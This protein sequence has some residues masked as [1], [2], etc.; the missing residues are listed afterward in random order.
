[1]SKIQDERQVDDE[2][3]LLHLQ[4]RMKISHSRPSASVTRIT[5]EPSTNKPS[6]DVPP[7][8]SANNHPPPQDSQAGV[9]LGD[10]VERS[11]TTSNPITAP[12]KPST[13]SAPFPE[14][15]HR[16]ASKF[17]LGR[18][19][20]TIPVAPA[21][22]TNINS[23]HTTITTT[24]TSTQNILQRE[25]DK[26]AS[27]IN[28]ENRQALEAMSQEEI[29]QAQMELL[30]KL[31]PKTIHFL[32]HTR[33]QQQQQQQQQNPVKASAISNPLLSAPVINNKE[34]YPCLASPPP[35]PTAP[36]ATTP[37]QQQNQG[38][39]SKKSLASRVRYDIDG[40]IVGLAADTEPNTSTSCSMYGSKQ[41]VVR[42]D[43]LR[44]DEGILPSGYTVSEASL[45][46][47][48]TVPQQ[49]VLALRLIKAVVLRSHPAGHNI[50]RRNNNTCESG[51][52]EEIVMK[53]LNN[54][55]KREDV[56]H[57]ALHEE[58]LVTRLRVAFD[59]NNLNVVSS[60][61]EALA[62]LFTPYTTTTTINNNNNNNN[63][64]NKS[65]DCLPWG[66]GGWPGVPLRHL[67]R[68]HAAAP[69]VAAPIDTHLQHIN[70]E[71]GG[72][73]G[74]GGEEVDERQ[75]GK[76]D[77]L[78]GLLNMNLLSR[79]VYVYLTLQA[80]GSIDAIIELLLACAMAGREVCRSVINTAGMKEVLLQLLSSRG[81]KEEEKGGKRGERCLRMVRLLAQSSQ[82]NCIS[83]FFSDD[84]GSNLR[85][86]VLDAL[87]LL[88]NPQ[89]SNVSGQHME[90]MEA[91]RLWRVMAAYNCH[92]ITMD[93]AFGPLATL[94]TTTTATTTTTAIT[95]EE[96]TREI[97]LTAG[98]LCHA[99]VMM[100]AHCAE[101]ILTMAV[102]SLEQQ[103]IAVIGTVDAGLTDD[104]ATA[105]V[106]YESI[107]AVLGY[108]EVYCSKNKDAIPSVVA[109]LDKT[110]L[111][112]S[113]ADSIEKALNGRSD[114]VASSSRSR[115]ALACIVVSLCVLQVMSGKI[116]TPSSS[117]SS[118]SMQNLLDTII[119]TQGLPCCHALINDLDAT[120]LQPWDLVIINS[121]LPLIRLALH[122]AWLS[123]T[124]MTVATVC[125]TQGGGGEEEEER[126]DKQQ[127]G[128]VKLA[129]TM[130]ATA[131]LTLP[132][133][134]DQSGLHALSIL[135]HPTA[136]K[137]LNGVV[138]DVYSGST[139]LTTPFD[140]HKEQDVEN[141]DVDADTMSKTLM[142][143]WAATWLG[144][145]REEEKQHITTFKTI[146]SQSRPV[147]DASNEYCNLMLTRL[148]VPLTL[149]PQG[150]SLPLSPDW[151]VGEIPWVPATS[152][153]TR[154][155]AA[156]AAAGYA[157]YYTLAMMHHDHNVFSIKQSMDNA[158]VV[159]SAVQLVFDCRPGETT[160]SSGTIVGDGGSITSGLWTD[161][162][163]RWSLYKMLQFH[164]KYL[165]QQERK[166][167]WT[168]PEAQSLVSQ[169]ASASYGDALFG[170]CVALLLRR[171]V[172]AT[173]QLE[174]LVMLAESRALHLLPSLHSCC[175]ISGYNL[176]E[177][178][179]AA[180]DAAVFLDPP[181]AQNE[182]EEGESVAYYLKLVEDGTLALCLDRQSIAADII[183]H[184]LAL[185]MY[186]NDGTEVSAKRK[187]MV[188]AVLRRACQEE[189][190]EEDGG[191]GN[192]VVSALVRWDTNEMIAIDVVTEER[193]EYIKEACESQG[194]M[195]LWKEVVKWSREA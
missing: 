99:G 165:K 109:R 55:L 176:S 68:P 47:R 132:P 89:H 67:L 9:F 118:S 141:T 52:G 172:P 96:V 146:S 162:L 14:A 97:Y 103:L 90:R 188:C 39:F 124:A 101:S 127:L 148:P 112:N 110:C 71:E 185:K 153:S 160:S 84:D 18:Q 149:S 129:I 19:R 3:E 5:R 57:H 179:L 184:R 38:G 91:L 13:T 27:S 164:P 86:A 126:E 177:S 20:K 10:V 33:K 105:V 135:T 21:T 79:I 7:P 59:D 130:A 64:N 120:L 87:L 159:K 152:S 2:L 131:L 62:A 115:N 181:R 189:E 17:A 11:P 102:Q 100:S 50:N 123:I 56:W 95:H 114:S 49:R 168:L 69:W 142:T 133:G 166:D 24:T 36:T 111:L 122:A 23:N 81:K 46:A 8:S 193:L 169:Y 180:A 74:G 37:K 140:T 154:A 4:E 190:E 138:K 25:E 167:E 155:A 48:S 104:D 53:R 119:T 22:T 72:G 88:T 144:M 187:A 44:T 41:S 137:Y 158:A 186:N 54:K 77:P 107:A 45:L 58:S 157:L 121:H 43:V 40:H 134:D 106:V 6:D 150:S 70:E 117:S 1:M 32:K 151:P 29:A 73:G 145:V 75:V 66:L 85:R 94:F 42:R 61:A 174:V 192:R 30:S 171:H 175:T 170:A 12:T 161:E 147:V 143:G 35:T 178:K 195:E 116:A 92:L 98:A 28:E 128:R 183:I 125:H 31:D 63:N 163:V 80:P 139:S 60:A 34:T 16:R 26:L 65:I 82:R 113:F 93:D 156:A 15:V 194:E 136:I 108:I 78:G 191:G 76:V 83:L 173:V 51:D 182:R